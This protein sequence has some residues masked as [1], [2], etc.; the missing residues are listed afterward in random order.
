MADRSHGA[1]LPAGGTGPRHDDA[2]AEPFLG[3]SED[4]TCHPRGLAT[5]KEARL[6]SAGY[7]EGCHDRSRSHPATGCHIPERRWTHSSSAWTRW[8]RERR[9]CHWRHDYGPLA[10]RGG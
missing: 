3:T 2:V 1:G 5:R 8:S 6:A 9:R 7:V 4:G 10:V